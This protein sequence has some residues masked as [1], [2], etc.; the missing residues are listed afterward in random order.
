ME[1]LKTQEIER[2]KESSFWKG[3]FCA[4][5]LFTVIGA[6]ALFS[7]FLLKGNLLKESSSQ[8]SSES[9]AQNAS[10]YVTSNEAVLRKLNLLEQIIREYSLDEVDDKRLEDYLYYGL[11]AGTGDAY[12]AYY[13]EEEMQSMMD[14]DAGSY[15]GIGAVFSQNLVTGIVTVSKVYEGFPAYKAGI[16]PQDMLYKVDGEVVTGEDLTIIVS[17]IKG[18]VGKEVTLTMVRGEEEI[19]FTMHCETIEVPTTSHEMLEGN[20][21]YIQITEFDEITVTQFES[22]LRELQSQGMERLI[23]DLRNNGG[24]SVAAVEAIGDMLLPEGDIVSIDYAYKEKET[25]T[26]DKEWVNVPMAVL[27]NG[28]SASA[29]EILAGAL[30]DHGVAKIV[31]TQTFGKGIVQN[32][33]SLTDGTAIEVTVAK[34]YTPNGNDIHKIGITP[35]IEIDLPE[36]LK[37]KVDLT[38]EEDVQL[39]KAIEVLQQ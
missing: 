8:N 16:L 6:I 12:A 15:G 17:R 34:Y 38:F 18:E 3:F 29:S 13:N 32:T 35:D 24:G 4:T 28:Y 36:E 1:E 22:A 33:L 9:P 30:Q 10:G 5:I 26:S 39:Q 27:V 14:S 2:K 11:V 19:D 31:G 23:V 7:G 20:V 21:G 25:R 37:V